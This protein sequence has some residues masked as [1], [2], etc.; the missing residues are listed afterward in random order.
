MYYYEV[1]LYLTKNTRFRSLIDPRNFD[2]SFDMTNVRGIILVIIILTLGQ[3]SYGQANPDRQQVSITLEEFNLVVD[4]SIK[5]LEG[6]FDKISDFGHIQIVTCFN[7]IVFNHSK[8]G[9]PDFDDPGYKGS[10]YEKLFSLVSSAKYLDNLLKK[11]P[12][13]VLSRGMGYYFP[14]L[15]L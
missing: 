13:F 8:I 6:E 3:S 11:Y 14:T 5:L 12:E 2:T 1:R 9:W 4:H 10:R 15:D 7:T